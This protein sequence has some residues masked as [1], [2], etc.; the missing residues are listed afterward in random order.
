MDQSQVS[1]D[2][3][4]ASDITCDNCGNYTFEQVAL[5]KK[6]SALLSPN[7]RETIVTLPV[8]AC[9]ACGFINKQFLPA[10]LQEEQPDESKEQVEERKLVLLDK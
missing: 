9:N 5:L 1:V 8:F 4:N 2:L 6:L 3:R 7:G 10:Q